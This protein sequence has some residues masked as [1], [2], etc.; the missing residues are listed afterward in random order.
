MQSRRIFMAAFLTLLSPAS[1]AQSAAATFVGTWK[2]DVPGIGEA[3]LIISAVGG[4]GRVEGRMEFALQGFVSTFADKADSVKR[5]SQGTV[6][7]GTLTIEAALGGRYVL[8]RTG[9][10]LS[11]RYIRGTTLDVPVT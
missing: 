10:G 11:G 9:E 2:G 6:A 3:T 7:E 8:R 4:D 1:R 5:T